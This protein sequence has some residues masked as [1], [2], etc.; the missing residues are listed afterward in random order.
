MATN[1]RLIEVET[2]EHVQAV[3]ELFEEYEKMLGIDLCFQNFEKELA[4]L[5][6]EYQPPEGRLILATHDERL[7]GCVAL[8]KIG[9]EICEMKRL[10]V[11]P[12][13][14]GTG[15]GRQL[16]ETLIEAAREIGYERMRLDTL[17]GKM[18]HAIAM[19]RRLGFKDIEPYYFNPVEGAAFMELDLGQENLIR[20][21]GAPEISK[22]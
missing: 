19:Y 20:R 15:L 12:D 5:P 6:G 9:P 16:A 3:R 14:R 21:Q 1:A 13:F 8:R 10:Y 22:R 17:P 18:D 4:N 7:A 11:R 2:E